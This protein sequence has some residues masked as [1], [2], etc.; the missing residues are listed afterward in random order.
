[1]SPALAGPHDHCQRS[2]ET[3]SYHGQSRRLSQNW[4]Q[5]A[6]KRKDLYAAISKLDQVLV[7]GAAA[8]MYHMITLVPS[9]QV[10]SHKLIVFRSR[11]S[12]PLQFS[13]AVFT[14]STVRS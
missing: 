1:M 12:R 3:G 13:K 4:W 9:T 5:H 10:F 7:T 2:G 6:E 11:R 14:R 8:V